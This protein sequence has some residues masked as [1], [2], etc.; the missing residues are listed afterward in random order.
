[1]ASLVA[2]VLGA[3]PNSGSAIASH[4]AAKGYKLAL[5]SRKAD[6]SKSTDSELHVAADFADPS[7]IAGVFSKV[8]AK[9]GLPNVVV[10]NGVS[11]RYTRTGDTRR[12]KD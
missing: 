12:R 9:L 1:M 3:G 6:E 8:K 4:L 10:Y 7:S 2:L 5:V 11:R